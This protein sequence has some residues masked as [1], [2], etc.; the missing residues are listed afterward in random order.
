MILLDEALTKR[1]IKIIPKK[2]VTKLS[3]LGQGKF[4]K[5]YK[6]SYKN[7]LVVIKKLQFDYLGSDTLDEIA[8]DITNLNDAKDE[9]LPCFFGIWK[10]LNNNQYNL[11]FE[12]FEGRS[13]KELMEQ[14]TIDQKLDIIIEVTST[15]CA[16][17]EKNFA[18]KDLK[19]DN[20]LVSLDDKRVKI[21]DFG[22]EKLDKK[23]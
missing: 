6:G 12:Y 3:L 19:P 16:L 8:E 20:I 4:G 2:E 7:K 23:H 9:R 10:G 1:G 22:T 15:L 5:V 14:L 13:L 17:H 11:I 18:H 21:L